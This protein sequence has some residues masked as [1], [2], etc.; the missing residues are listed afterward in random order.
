MYPGSRT[1]LTQLYRRVMAVR[2]CAIDI[3]TSS[4][5]CII[6]QSPA[7]KYAGPQQVVALVAW[8]ITRRLRFNGRECHELAQSWSTKWP[9]KKPAKHNWPVVNVKVTATGPSHLLAGLIISTSRRSEA[10]LVRSQPLRALHA[11]RARHVRERDEPR[12]RHVSIN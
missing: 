12:N 3:V 7:M 11:Q 10:W 1:S 8:E 5:L 4:L 9:N 2:I 6:E